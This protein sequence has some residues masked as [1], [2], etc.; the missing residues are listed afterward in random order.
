MKKVITVI[1]LIL[2]G[3]SGYSQTKNFI[4]QPFIEVQGTADSLVTPNQIFVRILLSEKD[5][6]DRVPLEETETKMVMALQSLGINTEKYLQASDM[7]SN[8]RVYFLKKR[9]ILKSKEYILE[10]STAALV[11]SVFI[12]L[13][14]LDISNV[15]VD[16]V[17]H[18]DIEG[19]KGDCYSK[20]IEAAKRKAVA[21]T[22]SIGQSVGNAI[23]ITEK[24]A[25]FQSQ[26]QGVA[27]GIRIR[28]ISTIA[29]GKQDL[30]KI[31]FEKIKITTSVNAAFIL[32]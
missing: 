19:I 25:G 1:I 14:N 9:D 2:V 13:E 31:E 3:L 21:L 28:G 20:A 24:E 26:L 10:V 5:T 22:R 30:P 15:S 4:D 16:R 29:Q 23:H 32:K 6:K 7:L 12:E 11:S 8:Y 18:T 27:A 17:G